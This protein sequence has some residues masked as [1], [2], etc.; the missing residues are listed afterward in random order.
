M[1][2]TIQEA[3]DELVLRDVNE[4]GYLTLEVQKTWDA[5]KLTELLRTTKPPGRDE[6]KGFNLAQG[7]S[8]C[9]HARVA[10]NISLNLQD[11]EGFS[12]TFQQA[13]Q[14]KPAGWLEWSLIR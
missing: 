4:R 13:S 11:L 7:T 8:D 1:V 10:R 6:I 3:R 14:V 2:A 12:Q 5:L 9:L